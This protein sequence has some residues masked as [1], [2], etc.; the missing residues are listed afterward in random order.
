MNDD[1]VLPIKPK[2]TGLKL[3]PKG[4]VIYL[5]PWLQFK[6]DIENDFPDGETTFKHMSKRLDG[7]AQKLMNCVEHI[8]K[9]KTQI[10]EL[11]KFNQQ[12]LKVCSE[13]EIKNQQLLGNLPNV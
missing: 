1:N 4:N 10:E 7:A 11:H 6:V 13:L 12:T 3:D 5:D 9:M 8:K 2:S